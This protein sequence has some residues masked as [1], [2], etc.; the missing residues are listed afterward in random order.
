VRLD[1]EF[2]RGRKVRVYGVNKKF[3]F[4]LR[5]WPMVGRRQ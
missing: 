2:G 3:S 4:F 1:A 5:G